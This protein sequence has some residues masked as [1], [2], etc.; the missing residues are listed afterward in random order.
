MSIDKDHT[1]CIGRCTWCP[2][3]LSTGWCC[4]TRRSHEGSRSRSLLVRSCSVRLDSYAYLDDFTAHTAGFLVFQ[5]GLAC[6]KE[7]VVNI[8]AEVFVISVLPDDCPSSNGRALLRSCH[9]GASSMF[10]RFA[11]F[12]PCGSRGNLFTSF[13][14]EVKHV[15]GNGQ[16]GDWLSSL[17]F[18]RFC[19]VILCWPRHTG[20]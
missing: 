16:F 10:F 15:A 14:K 1:W 17:W 3:E 11:C 9:S 20:H 12:A 2:H 7:R 13:C 6:I 19:F 8:R 18:F 5:R 4:S